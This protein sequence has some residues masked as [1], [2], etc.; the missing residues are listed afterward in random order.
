MSIKEYLKVPALNQAYQKIKSVQQI[1]QIQLDL[2]HKCNLRCT[3]CYY[4]AEAMDQY[5]SPKSES[6]FEQFLA[7]EKARGTNALLI[8]GGEP[9]LQ[10]ERLK[11]CYDNFH[12]HI[13]TNGAI[14]IPFNDFP[15]TPIFISL[16][17]D[18]K[19]DTLLR[20]Q[21]KVNVFKI[22]MENYKDDP[23]A[24]WYYTVTPGNIE[25]IPNVIQKCLDNGNSITFN[26]YGDIKKVGGGLDHG[27]GFEQARRDIFKFYKQYPER[28]W[29]T[30][31]LFDVITS[32][33]MKGLKW[34][35]DVC[36]SL[37]HDHPENKE[38]IESGEVYAKHL[39]VYQ[40]DLKTTR[41]CCTGD[42]RDCG[43]CYDAYSHIIWIVHN[44]KRH[45]GCVSD[46]A[47]WLMC[48][49]L[50]LKCTVLPVTSEDKILRDLQGFIWAS[51]QSE[52]EAI[53]IL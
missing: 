19:T 40:A 9:A 41:R 44:F 28:V 51:R 38:R 2:T 7:D 3:G 48:M 16:W 23:R 15:D 20:G 33:E 47:N 21:D 25:E 17:G 1:R 37:T 34:G 22:A 24:V 32:R 10:M 5:K 6:E 35:Y 39:R 27:L 14:K 11:Q 29:G 26:F 52:I 31:Y 8:T 43:N 18:E 4:F 42:A 30:P 50:Y 46:F 12:V 13:V 49:Y 36:C 53:E 45:L